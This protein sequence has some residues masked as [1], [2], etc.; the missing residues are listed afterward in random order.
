MA[1]H[2]G[3]RRPQRAG[4]CVLISAQPGYPVRL[5]ERRPAT[6]NSV[7]RPMN[8]ATRRQGHAMGTEGHAAQSRQF[9]A[10][11][12][13]RLHLRGG[14]GRRPEGDAPNPRLPPWGLAGSRPLDPS[15]TALVTCKMLK[16]NHAQFGGQDTSR[17]VVKPYVG[18]IT[19]YRQKARCCARHR[20]HCMSPSGPCLQRL[21]LSSS[22]RH[23]MGV[24]VPSTLCCSIGRAGRS[25]RTSGGNPRQPRSDP[26][27]AGA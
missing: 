2:P 3:P 17:R 24:C 10:W 16:L 7:S 19:S 8:L 21:V 13:S 5:R 20:L 9:G 25:V 12:K 15:H 22:S 11:F 4:T 27:P 14:W 26:G 18:N 6:P 1:S 23:R